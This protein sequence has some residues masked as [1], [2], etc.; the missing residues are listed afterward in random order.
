MLT[1]DTRDTIKNEIIPASIARIRRNYDSF[2]GLFPS[3]GNGD[4]AYLLT[5][6]KNWL[7]SFW[8][9][10][11]WLVYSQTQDSDDCQ[12]AKN[13]L[14]SFEARLDNKVHLN[15]DL[16][17]L[18]LLSAR[19]HHQY[20]EDD[21]SKALA[22]RAT[23]VLYKRFRPVGQYIQAWGEMDDDST[24]RR[25]IIDCMMNLP[26]LFWASKETGQLQYYA[27]AMAHARIS[28]QLLVRDDYSSYH[29]YVF[30]S[31]DGSPIEA[32]THQGY[33][34]D[35]LWARGQA[36]AVYG[37]T[38]AAEW[39]GDTSFIETAKFSTERYF[40]EAPANVIA[41]YDLRLPE[42][43]PAYPDSSADA[44]LASGLLRLAKLTGDMTYR[45]QAEKQLMMLYEDAFDT[46]PDAQ[47]LLLHG[48]QHAPHNYGVDTYTIFG[49]YFF[50]EGVL[51]LIDEAP[52]FWGKD[53]G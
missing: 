27:S 13:L 49:D 29:S 17:F 43:A 20:L 23:E 21:A 45:K 42:D 44:I 15:H 28:Q 16:G 10:L 48:T 41:P 3:Y 47:G 22:F 53:K 19:A 1:S 37:F 46:R 7:A 4:N 8:S 51:G 36:W 11:L 30:S 12:R 14:P 18:F 31:E 6:N 39:T 2:N 33:A 24:I 5:E 52:D 38:M 35:S 50:L 25:I 9:G 26:L 32:K 40:A 34:D